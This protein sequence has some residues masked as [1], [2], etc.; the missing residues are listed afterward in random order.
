MTEPQVPVRDA[1]TRILKGRGLQQPYESLLDELVDFFIVRLDQA[2]DVSLKEEL[3]RARYERD[4]ERAQL[5]S[6]VDENQ[7]LRRAL[8]FLTRPRNG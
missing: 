7:E 3:E 2:I 6:V 4:V 1:L 5:S 8:H